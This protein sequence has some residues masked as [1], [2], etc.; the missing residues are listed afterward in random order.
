MSKHYLEVVFTNVIICIYKYCYLRNEFN[1]YPSYTS[2][3][4]DGADDGL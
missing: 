3:T 2:I 1:S 4:W